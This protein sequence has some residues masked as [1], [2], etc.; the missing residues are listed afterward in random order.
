M[1]NSSEANAECGGIMQIAIKKGLFTLLIMEAVVIAIVSIAFMVN[2]YETY[3]NL[4]YRESAEI[5]NLHSII[6]DAKLSELE[7]LTFEILSNADIQANL[8][9]YY[10]SSNLYDS[11]QA[12]SDLYTQ[13]F[14]RW[15]MNKSIVSI[16]FV[17][18][19]GRRVDVG[20]QH[21]AS[22]S[23]QSLDRVIELAAS[24]NG[25]CGFV[26]NLAGDSIVTL[27][28]LIRDI[29]GNRFRPLGTLIMNVE[30]DPFFKYTPVVSENYEPDIVCVA[31][32]QIISRD[33]LPVGKEQILEVL[34]SH[35]RYDIV[36]L[37]GVPYFVSTK[38]LALNGWTLVYMV[39]TDDMLSSINKLNISY[40]ITLVLIVFLVVL[41]GYAFANAIT[42]PLTRL[43]RA[44]KVVQAGEYSA[45]LDA[46]SSND[47]I[48]VSEVVELSQGFSKM[49]KEIDHLISEVYRRQLMIMDMKYR[50]LQQQI[51][52]HFLY[53]TLDTINWKAVECRNQEI[54]LMVRSLSK[55][56]R[57]SIK[58]P[59]IITVQEDLGLVESYVQIQKIRFE[60]RLEFHSDV[61]PEALPCR[62]PRLTLQPI[63]ENCIIHNLEKHSGVCEISISA[64][65]TQGRLEI[66]VMDNGKGMDLAHVQDVL[67][68]HVEATNKSIGLRNIDQRIKMAFGEEYGIRVENRTPTG[69]V[70]TV[71][72][73]LR[74]EPY[75]DATDSG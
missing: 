13:L 72:L 55:L 58:G 51:N 60:E 14:T 25:S 65:I 45:A 50:M 24:K 56:L 9:K 23:G 74:G 26:A 20:R 34:D 22:L 71:I 75:V 48:A 68:G 52:P 35:N 41:V 30:A 49:V 36:R 7:S 28:R 32:D 2:L 61:G 5:L 18:L 40:T 17:F 44:M 54:P 70:V 39:S 53:N 8:T 29:S 10:D 73:P 11:Y 19:D 63:V 31:G 69:A 12:S 42:R 4:V 16:S 67:A 59:D 38:P 3:T 6:T 62:I 64:S 27:Y 1:Y 37:G 66:R 47:R 33:P 46:S 43:M 21:I 15:I 57:G